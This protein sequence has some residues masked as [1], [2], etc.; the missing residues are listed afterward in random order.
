MGKIYFKS[1]SA[2]DWKAHLADP[3]KQWKA[4]YSAKTLARCW[5]AADG[6]PPEIAAAI[7]SHEDIRATSPELLIGLPEWKVP[8]DGGRRDSQNDVFALV[9]CG[10]S[11]MAL[12]IE[13]KVDEAFGPTLGEWLVDASD[14]KRVRLAQICQLLA[15]PAEPPAQIRYQLLHRAASAVIEARRFGT[16]AAAM[17]V[18]SFSATRRWFEDFVA[19]A[20]L[21]GI[22]PEPDALLRA[23]AAAAPSLYFGWASGD[24]RFLKDD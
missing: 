24:P 22:K 4:G 9:R 7:R 1:K 17:I 2:E 12:M 14:G 18:H 15:L 13:G 6:L 23:D 10:D 20:A 19:F 5:D 3:G 11:V 8:L 16:P 21:F